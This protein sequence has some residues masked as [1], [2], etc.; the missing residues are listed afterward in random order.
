MSCLFNSI[1]LIFHL[2]IAASR[3]DEQYLQKW[4]AEASEQC[5][6]VER[7][8]DSSRHCIGGN[9]LVRSPAPSPTD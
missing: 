2:M 4:D 6:S 1:T 9:R 3:N 5:F 7:A 8:L